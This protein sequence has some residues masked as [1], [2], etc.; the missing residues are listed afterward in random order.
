MTNWNPTGTGLIN[1]GAPRMFIHG[2]SQMVAKLWDKPISLLFIDGDHSYEG[3]KKDTLSWEPF[4]KKG[5]TIL[6]HDTDY[7][8]GVPV[9]LDDH[10]GKGKWENH[11]SK[12]GR[13]RR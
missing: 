9:W 3:V 2:D 13:V 6:F 5:G 4:V 8:G 11:H 1:I 7:I 12:V 10:Y